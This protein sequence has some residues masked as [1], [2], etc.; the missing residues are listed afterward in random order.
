[1]TQDDPAF[2]IYVRDSTKPCPECRILIVRD[3]GCPAMRCTCGCTFCWLCGLKDL[4]CRCDVALLPW[5]A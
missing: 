5:E 1:M 2:A 4:A 3:G